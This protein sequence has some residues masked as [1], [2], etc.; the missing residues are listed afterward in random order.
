MKAW[1][2]SHPRIYTMTKKIINT[3]KS[4]SYILQS[5]SPETPSQNLILGSSQKIE[6]WLTFDI[7][8]GADYLGNIKNLKLFPSNSMD[9]VY[10]SHVLEHV[11]CADA[12][13]AVKEIHRVLKPGGEIFL[14]VPDMVTLSKLLETEFAETAIDIMFGVNRPVGDW[15]PQHQ[16]GYTRE[17]LEKLL[18]EAG[19]ITIKEFEPFLNDTTQFSI[20]ETK[21]SLCLKAYKSKSSNGNG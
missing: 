13:V 14:A 19:F 16:Y 17:L 9:K 15:Q 4:S 8:P 3:V 12:K 21:V 20:G 10:A 18:D 2:K 1:I 11:N 6:G 5:F 7:T